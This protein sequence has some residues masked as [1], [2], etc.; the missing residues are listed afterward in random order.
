MVATVSATFFRPGPAS[1]SIITYGIRAI[2][3]G[4]LIALKNAS[5]EEVAKVYESA[6][7]MYK[8]IEHLNGDSNLLRKLVDDYVSNASAYLALAQ[9]AL[10]LRHSD[11]LVKEKTACIEQVN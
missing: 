11:D 9:A 10:T 8:S 1:Q 7:M 5:F 6:H 3:F 2:G 4:Y